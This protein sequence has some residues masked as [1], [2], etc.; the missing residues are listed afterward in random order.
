MG[1]IPITL[2]VLY[3]YLSLDA[4]ICKLPLIVDISILVNFVEVSLRQ[5]ACH[6]ALYQLYVI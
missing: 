1:M 4:D 6:V 2:M 3:S 5:L